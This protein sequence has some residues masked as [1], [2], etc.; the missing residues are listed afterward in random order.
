VHDRAVERA[1]AGQR[2][3]VAL[4]GIERARLRR[5]DALTAAGGY[6]VSY[7][8]DV[9][10]DELSEIPDGTRLHVH[11]GT[12]EHDARVV[13]IGERHAQL[14]L[15]SQAVAAR[16]DR[17]VLRE[18][19]TVGGGIVVDPAPPRH[20]SRERIE[21]LAQGDVS[22]TIHAPVRIE[23]VRHLL[24]GEPDA[25]ECASGWLFAR[26]WL[27]D[28]RRELE[29][30]IDAA[31]P[32]DP[33]IPAPAEPWAAAVIPMVG[34]ERRGAKLYRPGA[35][36]SLR[37]RSEAATA[38]ERTLQEAGLEPVEI[39]DRRLAAHLE[40]EGRLVRLGDG[41]VI[42]P[43]AYEEA[44]RTLV[45]ECER[46]GSITLARFRDLLGVGR[47]TAQLLLERF[48]AD[49]L[50]RRAGDERVLRKRRRTV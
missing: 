45:A 21:L 7:R 25:L 13:R 39:E 29:E 43:S 42:A 19:T 24:D 8:L 6:P 50:T 36:A 22:A 20:S 46:A 3:A 41:R 2:V 28:L 14:R 5:G 33:G 27:E 1:A 4:P 23:T 34:L 18:R 37:E 35:R 10:L 30:R 49:R 48:D 38:L 44:K 17:V 31:D 40:H 26:A 11:H 9:S 16:G 15:A 47:R 32:L 12:A